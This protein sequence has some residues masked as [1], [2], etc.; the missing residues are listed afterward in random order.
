MNLLRY[1][2]Y[3]YNH[4]TF[5]S[6]MMHVNFVASSLQAALTYQQI[7]LQE[8]CLTFIENNTEVATTV[9]N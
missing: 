4:I 7:T 8:E 6:I 9:N 3:F 5:C 2:H 1:N